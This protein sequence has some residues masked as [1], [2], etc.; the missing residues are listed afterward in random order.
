MKRG[1]YWEKV[2]YFYFKLIFSSNGVNI[3]T[4][5]RKKKVAIRTLSSSTETK[6]ETNNKPPESKEQQQSDPILI[7]WEKQYQLHTA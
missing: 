3:L 5:K 4:P 6:T 7:E 2:L 1:F